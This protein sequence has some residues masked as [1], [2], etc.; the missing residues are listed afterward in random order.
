MPRSRPSS[1]RRGMTFMEVTLAVALLALLSSTV[2][3]AFSYLTGRQRL[4]QQK[5]GAA[6]VANRLM[7]QHLDDPDSMPEAGLPVEH[8]PDRYRWDQVQTPVKIKPAAPA[9]P[10]AAAAASTPA[11]QS[12]STLLESTYQLTVRVW[13]SEESGGSS[14]L[15]LSVPNVTL[16]RIVYPTIAGRNPD[17]MQNML[18]NN[19]GA[20][21]RYRDLITGRGDGKSGATP[22]Q[23][24]KPDG[25]KSKAK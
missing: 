8:G 5:L 24:R 18:K 1:Y 4:E 2:F 3:G 22:V 14:D 13:L 19:P 17:S 25:S 21:Q 7:L 12:S 6:E 10:Q 23:Q 9:N 20:M 11:V 15:D 16:T